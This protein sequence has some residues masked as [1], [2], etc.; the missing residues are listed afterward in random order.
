MSCDSYSDIWEPMVYSL[1]KFWPDC[2]FPTYLCSETKNFE[3]PRIGN[4]QVY[5]RMGWSE[6]LIS[7]LR[8]LSSKNVIYLQEDYILKGKTDTG[9]LIDLLEYYEKNNA[10][11]LRLIPYPPPREIIDEKLNVGKLE[12]GSQYRTSLQAAV[13]DRKV[14]LNL[15]D[16]SENGWQ[17]ERNS[18]E[19]SGHLDRPFYSV[20]LNSDEPNKNLHRYPLDYYSTAILQGKWQKEGVKLLRKAGVPIDTS[21]RGCLTRWDFFYYHEQKKPDSFYLQLLRFIDRHFFNPKSNYRKF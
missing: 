21:T 11:Y 12:K 19:R 2:P 14:L 18:V 13:W 8:Q 4:I 9:G 7:V 3:H 6:M 20:S 16:A 15:L 10:A 5:Q 17:F 1:D